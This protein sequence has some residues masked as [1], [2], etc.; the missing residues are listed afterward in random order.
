MVGRV[1][2]D[3]KEVRS[4]VRDNDAQQFGWDMDLDMKI[5]KV[6]RHLKMIDSR[7]DDMMTEF[8]VSILL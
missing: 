3:V 5:D 2:D 6:L 1:L 4:L 8:N 7:L